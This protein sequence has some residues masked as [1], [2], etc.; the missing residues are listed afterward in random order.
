MGGIV[1]SKPTINLSE[2]PL[3]TLVDPTFPKLLFD[4]FDKVTDFFNDKIAE[5]ECFEKV[6]ENYS[7]YYHNIYDIHSFK[8]KLQ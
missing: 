3:T 2:E 8:K 4:H 1:A 7:H 6:V 5:V